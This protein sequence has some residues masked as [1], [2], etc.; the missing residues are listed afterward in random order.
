MKEIIKKTINIAII[1]ILA[2]SLLANW[3]LVSDKRNLQKEYEVIQKENKLLTERVTS[4]EQ[5]LTDA[6]TMLDAATK[7]LQSLKKN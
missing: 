7:E 4:C 5:D 1:V 3:A 2:F 6:A